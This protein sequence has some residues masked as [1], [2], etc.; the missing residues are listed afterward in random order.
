VEACPVRDKIL[1]EKDYSL[2][3]CPV[4]RGFKLKVSDSRFQVSRGWWIGIVI[5]EM[6]DGKGG[7]FL[8]HLFLCEEKEFGTLYTEICG[9]KMW[10]LGKV[11]KLGVMKNKCG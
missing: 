9:L 11:M 5:G 6:T 4:G 3:S 8:C 10:R 2:S 1:V 7:G